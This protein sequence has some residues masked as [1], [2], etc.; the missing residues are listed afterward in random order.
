M[1][2]TVAAA[3]LV[4]AASLALFTGGS[5][6]ATASSVLA[7][8]GCKAGKVRPISIT[9]FCADNGAGMRALRWTAWGGTTARGSGTYTEKLCSPTCATG[10]TLT[11]QATIR[12][13]RRARCPGRV[14]RYYRTAAIRLSNGS[15]RQW[16]VPCPF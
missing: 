2:R 5:S 13:T 3:C 7:T 8:Q 12:L 10:G 9:F 14:G 4:A 1:L 6:A 16:T 15:T 11:R